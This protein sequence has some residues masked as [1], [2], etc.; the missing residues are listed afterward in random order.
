MIF[1]LIDWPNRLSEIFLKWVFFSVV[2]FYWFLCWLAFAPAM[3]DFDLPFQY[4]WTDWEFYAYLLAYPVM[5]ATIILGSVRVAARIPAA[6]VILHAL[7][8]TLLGGAY[9]LYFGGL[10]NLIEV[11]FMILLACIIGKEHRNLQA[12]S[13]GLLILGLTRAMQLLVALAIAKV[14]YE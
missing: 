10:S 11:P 5:E 3:T 14:L 12:F 6:A 2:R 1:Y 7:V 13:G 8:G 9:V 4:D